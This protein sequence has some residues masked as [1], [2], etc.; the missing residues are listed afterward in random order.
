LQQKLLGE[1]VATERSALLFILLDALGYDLPDQAWDGLLQG[2]LTITAYV[3]SPALVRSLESAS[4][5]KRLGETVLL[6]LLALGDVG[7]SSAAPS[8]LRTVIRALNGVGL[9]AE[10]RA[11]ALEAALGRGF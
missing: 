5:N 11:L 6:G 3:P 2:S 10:A 4:L 9:A 7:P 1:A 8:T